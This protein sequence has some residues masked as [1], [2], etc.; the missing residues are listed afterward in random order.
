MGTDSWE[1]GFRPA[2]LEYLVPSASICNDLRFLQVVPLC[3]CVSVVKNRTSSSLPV[4]EYEAAGGVVV[5]EGQVLLLWRPARNEIRLPKGHVEAGETRWEAALR[6]V[7]EEGGVPRPRLVADLG[8]QQLEFEH[9][10][11]RVIRQEFYFLMT[12]DDFGGCARSAE[13]AVEF[14]PFWTAIE[15]AEAL[16]T[17][18]TEREFLRRARAAL[19]EPAAA[20][21]TAGAT[22]E[23]P[24]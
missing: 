2:W 14:E 4:R 19:R 18:P 9:A 7:R 21:P 1:A 13:D 23:P 10:G 15:N 17:F 24:G 8:R 5:R 20:A 12:V 3:L 6:E 11:F 16:L 22:P